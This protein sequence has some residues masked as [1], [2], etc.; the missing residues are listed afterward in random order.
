M[1]VFLYRIDTVDNLG[2]FEYTPEGFLKVTAPIAKEGILTYYKKDGTTRKEL[3]KIDELTKKESL[4]TLELKPV[5]NNHPK[6]IVNK[7]NAKLLNIG[8]TGQNFN[9]DNNTLLVDFVI[10]DDSAIQDIQNGKR[11]LSPGYYC[12]TIEEPGEYNGERYDA[13]QTNRR[14]NHL[15][16]CNNAR[17]GSSLKIRLDSNNEYIEDIE[18]KKNEENQM[19]KLKID[20]AEYEVDNAVSARF[21]SMQATIDKLTAEKDGMKLKLDEFSKRDIEK[22]IETKAQTIA[23][24]RTYILKN[25]E[26]VLDS[27]DESKSSIDIMKDVVLKKHEKADLKDKSETYIRAR[28][29]SIVDDLQI[30]KSNKGIETQ[31]KKLENFK[32][33]SNTDLRAK[34]IN[35]LENAWKGGK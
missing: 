10:T 14:Y 35:Q 13:I 15:A 33:D 24:E 20:S 25:A 34:Y 5:T 29:D 32:Q 16:I 28:F 19:S 4:K 2:K 17:G 30:E 12:D 1:E 27:V 26:L 8:L 18:I 22:E 11:E 9:T 6:D 7:K 31:G 21:D 3:I 23:K